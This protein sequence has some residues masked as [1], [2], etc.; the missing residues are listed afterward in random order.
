MISW[1]VAAQEAVRYLMLAGQQEAAFQAARMHDA[2]SAF[3][4]GLPASGPAA[5]QGCEWA[6]LFYEERALWEAS[7][8]LR[9]RFG[10]PEAAVRL[11]LKVPASA[12][13]PLTQTDML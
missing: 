10:D 4:E 6:C 7:A 1:D 5:E 11:Y 2:M 8:E 9:D 13:H 3:V 12:E